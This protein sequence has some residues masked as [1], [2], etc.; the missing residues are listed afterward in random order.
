[1][2]LR[3]YGISLN[4]AKEPPPPRENVVEFDVQNDEK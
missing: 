2:L 1:M 3:D 4:Q